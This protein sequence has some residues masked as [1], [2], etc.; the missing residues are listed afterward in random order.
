VT[1]VAAPR[2]GL[3]LLA[4]LFVA[5]LALRPQL[6]GTG[7]LLPDIEA[8]LGVSHAVAGL[9]GTIPVLC[10]GVFAPAA[11]PFARRT[12][13]RRAVTLSVAA[14]AL[15]GLARATV[16]G[17]PLLLALTLPVGIGM[18]LAGALLPVAVKARFADRPAFASGVCTT[19][20]NLGAALSA[21]AAVP[22]ATAFGGWSGAL[23]AFSVVALVQC[24]GW[25]MLSRGAWIE[26]AAETARMPLRRP[27]LWMIL[28]VFA[29]QSLVYYGVTTW[30]ADAFQ[31]RGWSS[32]T[33]GALVAVMGLGMVP[34]GLL[35]PWL[36]DR[37]GSRRQWLL[38][39]T[40][41]VGVGTFGLAALPGAGFLW[42]ALT[43]AAIGAV[44][45]LCLTMCLDVAHEPAAAGAA[46]AMMFVGGYLVAAAAPLGL[47]AVRDLTGSFSASLWALF[48]T[49]VLL[50]A[51]CLP[52]NSTRLQPA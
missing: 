39:M 4:A 23:A 24:A 1:A 41:T 22:A 8:D 2:R 13:L 12:G 10:M 26:R 52:L 14:V 44:F 33:T 31:E 5:A 34:G 7:P 32:A 38:A 47:G 25:I 48:G 43:G 15:F 50:V 49:A 16:P 46:T 27:V 35:V 21:A 37:F 3:T 17:V 45:P 9:L 19:G 20:L 6:V 42:A 28:T 29:L 18:A 30:L 11:A 51:A 40:S 36:A